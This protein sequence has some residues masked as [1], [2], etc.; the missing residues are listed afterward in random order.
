MDSADFPRFD[1]QEAVSR[2]VELTN[3]SRVDEALK[4][5]CISSWQEG[6]A[7]DEARLVLAGSAEQPEGLLA[8]DSIEGSRASWIKD[9]SKLATMSD[10]AVALVRRLSEIFELIVGPT[11]ERPAAGIV[12]PG[13]GS[14]SASA[15][16]SGGRS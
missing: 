1:F 7:L 6:L 8:V 10:A 12:S 16:V 9:P 4:S 14:T 13:E 2:I 3:A 15:G 5:E 11:L